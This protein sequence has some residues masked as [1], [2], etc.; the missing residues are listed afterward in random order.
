MVQLGVQT[1]AASRSARP[2]VA[3]MWRI[4]AL[5]LGRARS[6]APDMT[7]HSDD[8]TAL[9]VPRRFVRSLDAQDAD[10]KQAVRVIDAV[11]PQ[12]NALDV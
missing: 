8:L 10:A 12:L 6:R 2:R 4:S 3:P 11:G 5:P 7:A 9:V 1:A